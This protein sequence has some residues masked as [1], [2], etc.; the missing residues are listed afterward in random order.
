MMLDV[1]RKIRRVVLDTEACFVLYS[2]HAGSTL[3]MEYPTMICDIA[4]LRIRKNLSGRKNSSTHV[5]LFGPR[6]ISPW[7]LLNLPVS[8]IVYQVLH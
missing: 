4:S 8:A 6:S 5:R 3:E 7:L 1:C 2:T